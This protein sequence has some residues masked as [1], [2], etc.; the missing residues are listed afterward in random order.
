MKIGFHF[1]IEAE[2]LIAEADTMRPLWHPDLS[3]SKLN[4]MLESIPLDGL[5]SLE[6][7][8]LERPHHKLMP[9]AV[10]GYHVPAPDLSPIDLLP[11]GLEIR[12]PVCDSIEQ[13]LDCFKLLFDRLETALQHAGYTL[14]SLSHHPVEHHFEGPQNKRRHDFWQWAM[15]VMVTYGPDINVSLPHDLAAH[16]DPGDLHAKVN[17]YGPAMAALSLASPLY[18][19]DLW[20]I[21]G[22]IGKSI[23]T[24]RRS[25]IAPA[26]ELH[27]EENGRLEFKLFEATNCL[28]DYNA[29]FLLWLTVLLDE[30]LLGRASNAS[31]VY[32]LGAAAR[33]GMV[34]DNVRARAS[35]LLDR[36]DAVLSRFGFESAPLEALRVRVDTGRLPADDMIQMFQRTGSLTE[37]LRTRTGLSTS[38]YLKR[39]AVAC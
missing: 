29:F 31:R 33:F 34:A 2:F 12:T 37:V 9:Y 14:V 5:P 8:E 32:D 17:Y 11:K 21:R 22:D 19:G 13:T 36:A 35:E 6:G 4:R 23:R 25:V 16:M 7:L 3:F 26:I 39:K 30:G 18:R 38:H 15:E 27:P 28:G 20:S 10:E 1:G 24:Y